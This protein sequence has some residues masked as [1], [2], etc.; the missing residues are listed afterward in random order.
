[1]SQHMRLNS[2]QE[3]RELSAVKNYARHLR[4]VRVFERL[5]SFGRVGQRPVR[6]IPVTVGGIESRREKRV[7]DDPTVQD[8]YV[9]GANWWRGQPGEQRVD[10]LRLLAGL[11]RQKVGG[12]LLRK[13]HLPDH[14][15]QLGR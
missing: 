13:P 1:M 6:V 14:V 2:G 4:T 5:R 11:K 10:E 7:N 9:R 3:R 15:E 8:A 12:V